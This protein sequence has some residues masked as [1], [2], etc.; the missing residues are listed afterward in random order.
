MKG[1]MTPGMVNRSRY[2]SRKGISLVEVMIA[3]LVLSIMVIGAAAFMYQSS[4]TILEQGRRRQALDL[5]DSRLEEIRAVPV[6]EL[7]NRVTQVLAGKVGWIG[8]NS[9][10][11]LTGSVARIQ[12]QVVLSG[13][14]YTIET[15][16]DCR[17]PYLCLTTTVI[18]AVF[19]ANADRE[20]VTA[21]TLYLPELFYFP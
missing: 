21:S 16:A 11:V 15:T 3:L 8:K 20:R 14:T 10:G 7:T 2:P 12:D 18:Y 19:P 6:T 9:G 17:Q 13:H 4:S 5:A 1:I